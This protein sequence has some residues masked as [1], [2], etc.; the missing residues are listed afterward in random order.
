MLFTFYVCHNST[1]EKFDLV[2]ES[3]L[4]VILLVLV[5]F[6]EFVHINEVVMWFINKIVV[7]IVIKKYHYYYYYY[8]Y[9]NNNYY[10]F[11]ETTSKLLSTT[12]VTPLT[13][14]QLRFLWHH[15]KS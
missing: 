13:M 8:F 4:E 12:I 11:Y 5:A 10:Y 3:H 7:V 2:E 15:F 14:A 6:M 1:K 9:Y